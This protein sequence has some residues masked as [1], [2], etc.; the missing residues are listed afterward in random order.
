MIVQNSSQKKV[1]QKM[2]GIAVVLL[3][4][5][6]AFARAED[7][8][9]TPE[10]KQQGWERLFD[11]K[12]LDGWSVKSGVAKYEVVDGAIVGRTAEGS[13]NTFLCTDRIFKDFEITFDVMLDHD[14]LNSGIQIRSKLKGEQ[15]GG[16]VYGPQVEIMRSPGFSGFVYAEAVK[17]WVSQKR[18]NNYIGNGEWNSYRIHVKGVHIRTWI[19][20]NAVEDFMYPDELHAINPDGFFGLQVHGIKPGL[21]PYS[22]RWK[23]I[24]V[25]ELK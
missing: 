4:G 11:G 13:P 24:F 20:G 16:R 21:G 1:V 5:C 17:G 19:N 9:L 3:I 18:R 6:L 2:S 12:T 10:Q 14:E 7:N 15:Y 23:N 8:V 22:V 25:K